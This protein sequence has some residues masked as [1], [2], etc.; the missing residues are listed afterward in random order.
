M[1]SNSDKNVNEQEI[2]IHIVRMYLHGEDDRDLR[3]D[4]CIWIERPFVAGN[5]GTD[6]KQIDGALGLGEYPKVWIV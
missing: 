1:K 4:D 6:Q 5:A 3:G 2:A